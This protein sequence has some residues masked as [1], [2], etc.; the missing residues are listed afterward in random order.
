MIEF[1]SNLCDPVWIM[2]HG[3]LY[4]IVV[5]VFA[6]TGLFAGFFLPG[7]TLLFVAG[8]ILSHFNYPFNT[9]WMSVAYWLL[10]ITAAGIAG[11]FVGYWFGRKSGMLLLEK[12][13]SK[14]FKKKY[15]IKAKDFYENRGGSAIV[16]ARF[17]PLVRTFAPIVAG[18]VRMDFR[19]FS[20]YNIAGSILWVVTIVLAGYFL[21]NIPFVKEHLE[22]I[23]LGIVLITTLP[24]LIKLATH[25]KQ[26]SSRKE[27][28]L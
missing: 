16:V 24:V 2:Q 25:K 3:G 20:C 1:L 5:I 6:E 23:I 12:K 8:V 9:E 10:L 18:M 4:I 28:L 26:K 19:K 7:D 27:S 11:N 14:F 15:L 17:L 21:G 22:Y 13:D